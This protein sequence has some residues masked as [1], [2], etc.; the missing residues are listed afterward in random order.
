MNVAHTKILFPILG[1]YFRCYLYISNIQ[2]TFI[3]NDT[4]LVALLSIGVK[5][6]K[7]LH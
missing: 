3:S 6:I 2:I 7:F 1:V 5:T 4:Y